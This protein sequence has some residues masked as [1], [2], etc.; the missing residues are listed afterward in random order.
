M[1]LLKVL[2]VVERYV[3]VL[4]VLLLATAQLHVVE[5]NLSGQSLHVVAIGVLACAQLAFDEEPGAFL[6]VAL[7]HLDDS[8]VH[9]DV[10][11][12]C[13]LGHL[14]AVTLGVTLVGCR[15]AEGGK[16][17]AVALSDFG[18]VAHIA[19]QK[20]FVDCHSNL[21]DHLT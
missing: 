7:D 3:G 17:A 9:H 8:P 10:V 2:L 19:E 6:D 1:P 13:A 16:L 18:V 14:C 15:K 4:L 12:L 21:L 5:V 11:P 20:Y